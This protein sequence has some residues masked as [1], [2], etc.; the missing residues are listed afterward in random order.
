MHGPVIW[1]E[2]AMKDCRRCPE[3]GWEKGRRKVE[4]A[5]GGLH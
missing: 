1:R 5:R 2:W 4:I 3:S